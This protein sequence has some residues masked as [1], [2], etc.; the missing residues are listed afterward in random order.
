MMLIGISRTGFYDDVDTVSDEERRQMNMAPL[1]N[2]IIKRIER[3][4]V[5][6]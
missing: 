6:G 4:G 1:V 2:Q 5:D 3:H